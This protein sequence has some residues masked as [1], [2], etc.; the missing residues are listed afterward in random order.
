MNNMQLLLNFRCD[1]QKLRENILQFFHKICVIQHIVVINK[2]I[3]WKI[4]I[5]I[6]NVKVFSTIFSDFIHKPR[7]MV[8]VCMCQNPCRNMSTSNIMFQKRHILLFAAAPL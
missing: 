4:I 8:A 6:L 5:Y 2:I 7:N 1:F 3:R